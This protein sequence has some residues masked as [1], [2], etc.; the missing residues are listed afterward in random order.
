MVPSS[1]DDTVFI[2][3]K[4]CSITSIY[5][6]CLQGSFSELLSVHVY[7]EHDLTLWSDGCIELSLSRL[8]GG[9]C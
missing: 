4:S 9:S 5:T 6:H 8:S 2:W 1:P 3:P 7:M